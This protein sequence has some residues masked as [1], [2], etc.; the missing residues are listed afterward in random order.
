MNAKNEGEM[1]GN[2][3]EAMDMDKLASGNAP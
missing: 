1:R 2:V 3:L